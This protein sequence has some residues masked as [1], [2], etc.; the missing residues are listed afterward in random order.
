M[1][2]DIHANA[3][4]IDHPKSSRDNVD[5]IAP[6]LNAG[7]RVQPGV[8]SRHAEAGIAI[9]VYKLYL[10][11]WYVQPRGIKNLTGNRR[12]F[13]LCAGKLAT[14]EKNS[15]KKNTLPDNYKGQRASIIG[16][17]QA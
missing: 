10:G 1:I 9:D 2:L 14:R 13:G 8:A 6:R 11:T 17:L 7:E 5:P 3:G 12:S 4:D 15:N 16:P